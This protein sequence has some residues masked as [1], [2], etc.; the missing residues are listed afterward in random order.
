MA[1]ETGL[2]DRTDEDRN[3]L[4]RWS[5]LAI[6]DSDRV[7]RGLFAVIVGFFLLIALFPFYW[8]L[9]LALTPERLF[10]DLGLVPIAFNVASFLEAFQAVPFHWYMLN[11]IVMALMTTVIVIVIGSVAGYVFGRLDFRGKTALLLAV[12]I[13]SYFPPTAFLIPLFNLLTGNV[14]VLGISSP[15]LYNGPGAI[16]LPLSALVMPL[17]IYILATFFSQIPDGLEDASRIEGSTRLGALYRV[18]MPLAAPGVATIAIL[19]FIITYNEF[20]FSFLM[21]NGEP[22][23]W[24]P[25]VWGITR[26]QG[27]TRAIQYNL[28]AAASIV[29]VIPMAVIVVLAQE[30]I[31]SGL[32]AGAL[33]E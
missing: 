31:V 17:A 3:V 33:K 11:S 1:T 18:I 25:I 10:S 13:I 26:Y 19:T 21:T 14:E 5:R 23:N 22:E 7:Y 2:T 8:L 28:M 20:F 4:E 30:K 16:V 29:G 27:A 6:L 15:R 24:S 9:L 32:T 12:L